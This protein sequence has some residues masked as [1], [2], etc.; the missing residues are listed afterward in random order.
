MAAATQ[1]VDRPFT[2]ALPKSALPKGRPQSYYATHFRR[3]K[4]M[5][6]AIA[7]LET[8]VRRAGRADD[9]RIRRTA[10][11]IGVRQPSDQTCDLVRHL[12]REGSLGQMD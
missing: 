3:L 8:G 9:D 1:V 5:R 4:A 6:L 11:A 2:H 10:A 12:I 7:L